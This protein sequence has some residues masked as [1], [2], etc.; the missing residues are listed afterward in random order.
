VN[1]PR[2][3]RHI[4][5]HEAE[6]VQL[7]LGKGA[8]FGKEL[9]ELRLGAVIEDHPALD[10]SGHGVDDGDGGMGGAEEA[11]RAHDGLFER[12]KPQ[13][14]RAWSRNLRPSDGLKVRNSW[15]CLP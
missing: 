12:T 15:A 7:G 6:G 3:T 9:A 1:F 11:E 2:A 14:A 10:H 13:S 8:L 5:P 4:G